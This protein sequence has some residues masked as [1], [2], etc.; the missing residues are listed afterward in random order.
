MAWMFGLE[1]PSSSKGKL[2]LAVILVVTIACTAWL[3]A[4]NAGDPE[5]AWANP[6]ALGLGVEDPGDG[7]A[8]RPE[9]LVADGPS[10]PVVD[11]DMD[12]TSMRTP[13]S[14]ADDREPLD[15]SVAIVAPD[16]PAARKEQRVAGSIR[17]LLL[18]EGG[19]WTQETLPERD[20][21]MLDLVPQDDPS[22]S[23]R[24]RIEARPIAA[25]ELELVFEFPD[26]VEGDYELTLSALG[27]WR[28]APVSMRVQPP[29]SGIVFTRYDKDPKLRLEFEVADALTSERVEA[30]QTR[31]VQLTP[32]DDNGVFLHT[33]PLDV[34]SF[35]I[36]GRFSWSLWANGYAPAFGDDTAFVRRGDRRVAHVQL[37]RG[38]STLLLVLAR[39]PQARQVRGASVLVDGRVVG[40]TRADGMLVVRAGATPESLA[41]EWPGWRMT[42]DPLE[43]YLGKSAAQRGQVTIVML[44][45]D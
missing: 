33:G 13:E 42:S 19:P 26:L 27:S 7:D 17:G 20:T 24:G 31:H 44:E 36:D 1:S 45:R 41:V 38:W 2:A 37:E 23:L 8:R 21:V 6:L 29:M 35:P 22:R 28:W 15:G 40:V 18:R 30:F 10:L 32:S 3:V 4:S 39:D 5:V 12:A 9:T 25:G 11:D 14:T 34:D 16:T 43:P